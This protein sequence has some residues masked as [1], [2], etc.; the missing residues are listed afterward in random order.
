M[1]TELGLVQQRRGGE[2]RAADHARRPVQRL[3]GHVGRALLAPALQ[4]YTVH[5]TLH[6]YSVQWKRSE[7]FVD[8][9]GG[10]TCK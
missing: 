7:N 3:P 8:R 1:L 2:V 4:R 10:R 9:N 6:S 5:Y